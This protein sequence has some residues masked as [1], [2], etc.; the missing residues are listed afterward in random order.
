MNRN[1]VSRCI[2]LFSV[3]ALIW[4][5]S[6][7]V[8]KADIFVA[9]LD[10]SQVVGSS[11]EPGSAV[12]TFVLDEAQE[13]LSYSIQIFGLDLKPVAAERTLFSDVTA[14]HLHN[15]FSGTSGPHVLNVFGMPSEDDSEMVVDFTNES[16]DGVFNDDDAIDPDTG[17]LFDQNNPG[18]TKLFSNFVDD[19]ISGQIYIAIHSAG[20]GGDIAIRGQVVAVPEPSSIVMLAACGAC[21]LLRRRTHNV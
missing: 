10:A 18:T 16:I 21:C 14:I 15:G 1:L 17:M 12:A 20:Q 8:A 2:R 19:L 11:S 3:L 4:C 5:A 6:V 7:G 9:N 13:N